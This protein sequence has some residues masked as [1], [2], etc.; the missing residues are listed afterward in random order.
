MPDLSDHFA[1]ALHSVY[2]SYLEPEDLS[3][4]F[5]LRSDERGEVAELVRKPGAGQIFFSRT[6]PGITRGNH[7]HDTKVERFIVLAGEG[8]VRLRRVGSDEVEEFVVSGAAPRAVIIPPGL[9]RT[10]S[11]TRGATRW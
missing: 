2:L 11:R 5:T 9:P 8:V 4:P 1:R 10:A 6:H 3:F 7:Y